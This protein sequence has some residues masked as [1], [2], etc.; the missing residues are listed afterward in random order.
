[1]LL[2]TQALHEKQQAIVKFVEGGP[3]TVAGLK[4]NL[5]EVTAWLSSSNLSSPNPPWARVNHL[6]LV[7]S[8]FSA[9]FFLEYFIYFARFRH[10]RSIS[11]ATSVR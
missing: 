1:M 11:C 6:F 2:E 8:S 3:D 7:F 10:V 4:A 9:L 5:D